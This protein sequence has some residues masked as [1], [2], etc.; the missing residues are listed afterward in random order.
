MSVWYFCVCFGCQSPTRGVLT[1]VEADSWCVGL[2]A[3]QVWMRHQICTLY[4]NNGF[5][6]RGLVPTFTYNVRTVNPYAVLEGS[7][8]GD[9]IRLRFS[10]PFA[11][12][13]R[14]RFSL[15]LF[16]APISGLRFSPPHLVF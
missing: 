6:T 11:L 12:R 16:L 14:L 15:P 7:A 5:P 2:P 8:Q 10:L 3:A 1:R 9:W 13:L 4:V